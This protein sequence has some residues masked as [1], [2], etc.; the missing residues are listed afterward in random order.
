[1]NRGPVARSS[2]CAL[3]VDLVQTPSSGGHQGGRRLGIRRACLI[4]G[5]I[6]VSGLAVG[7]AVVVGRGQGPTPPT[8]CNFA[9]TATSAQFSITPTQAQNAAIIAAVAMRKGMPDHAV[10]IA[11]ATSLQET[12]LRN[13]PYGDLDS[14]GLFQQRPSQG[15]GTSA[16][17]MDPNYAAS[18][19][20]DHLA[21]V[22]GWQTM[23]VTDA[24][25]LVQHSATPDAYANWET[26]ARSLAIALTGEVPAG[27]SCR[28]DGF[29]GLAPPPSALAQASA[30]EM[31]AQL[32]GVPVSTKAGW[33]VATWAVAHAYN[34]HISSVSFESRTWTGA[35]GTWSPIAGS[36][37]GAAQN[38]VNVT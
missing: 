13:L 27:L 18:T 30:Q 7:V 21:Q 24:A 14:V 1:M 3:V 31:G 12:Q 35:S 9:S 4:G 8:G 15:W 25:Q 5:V 28:L 33:R 17:I 38:T 32:L 29:G 2:G 26:E 20:Y 23:A 19:F 6:A 34:Y 22:P 11:L 16:Q 36:E 37:S 10:T